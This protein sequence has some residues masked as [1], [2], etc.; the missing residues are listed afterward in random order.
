MDIMLD[1]P[2]IELPYD[3]LAGIALLKADD[4]TKDIPVMILT[5]FFEEGKVDRAKRAGAVD[6][7]NLQGH[8]ISTIPKIFKRYLDDPKNYHPGHPIFMK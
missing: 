4:R 3:G 8:S 7:I 5:N 6:Y 2:G 1:R